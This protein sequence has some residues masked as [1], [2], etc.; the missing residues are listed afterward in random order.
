MAE[1]GAFIDVNGNPFIT[2][3][4]TPFALYSKGTISS[5]NK[6]NTQY[7]ERYVNIPQG[8]P[9][10][11]FCKTTNTSNGTALS[12]FTF[13]SGANVGKIY[14][15]GV[16]PNNQSFVLTYYIFAIFPQTLPRWGMAIWDAQ[17]K[18]ILTNE[19][20]VLSDLTTVGTPGFSGGGL[21]IDV[22]LNGSW[23]VVPTILGNSQIQVGTIPTGQPII[24]NATAGS[25]CRFD[26]SRTRI[27]AQSTM[28][29]GNVLST[30]NNGNVITAINTAAYD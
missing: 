29:S 18:L 16:N 14:F 5:G 1:Y 27:N 10:I 2:P 21:N 9:V 23:A 26:G 17:G 4:S 3:L 22:T 30:T 15:Q 20:K 28:G 13:R 19:T 25:S 11:A 24:S 12:A 7:A 6:N 8:V